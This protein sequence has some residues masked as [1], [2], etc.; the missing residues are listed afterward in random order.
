MIVASKGRD[1]ELRSSSVP[2]AWW[3]YGSEPPAE[4]VG[5][6]AGTGYG[7]L[8]RAL[9]VPALL[10]IIL[11]LSQGAGMVPAKVYRG[12]G[13]TREPA[14]DSYQYDLI[15]NRP[16]SESTPFTFAADV[17]G[18]IGTAG[19]VCLE[20]VKSRGKVVE[21]IVRDSRKVRPKRSG[22]RL[23][24]EDSEGNG[25]TVVRDT[26]EI[27]YIR[28]LALAGSVVGLS[29]ITAARLGILNGLK[30]Q[31]FEYRYLT[32]NAQAGVVLSAPERMDRPTADSWLEAWNEVGSG[33]ENHFDTRMI[34]GGITATPMPIKMSDAQFVEANNM[35]GAQ[36]GGIYGFP[37]AFLNL[38]DNSPTPEDWRFFVTFGLGWILTTIAQSLTADRDLFP[39]EVNPDK[40]MFV[41][42]IAEALLKPD[43]R[44]RYEAYRAA[45]QA[46][47]LTSNEIR[48]IEN[49][50][51]HDD[52][53]VLQVT[54]VGGGANPGAG[55]AAYAL[56]DELQSM[57][58]DADND[59]E[60]KLL[61]LAIDRGRATIS[62]H[63]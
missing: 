52:G 2:S 6:T 10:G 14:V 60:R 13:E 46:G 28:G 9:G 56:M 1:I 19:Y 34:G 37:K 3:P 33:E 20:K 51:P 15:H 43:I 11:R 59:A 57:H 30:R 24:F 48:A 35:T 23:V 22:G 63:E 47:W 40:R 7:S 18:A 42:H 58:A 54:P 12:A 17:A 25:Q 26:R 53:D 31:M 41:E 5:G 62:Q 4:L 8:E 38:G 16:S 55:P 50:P 45:R 49:L 44:T 27:I 39:L 61:Q 29:P 21:L 32:K 36:L